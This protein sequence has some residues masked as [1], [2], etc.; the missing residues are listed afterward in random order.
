MT[1]SLPGPEPHVWNRLAEDAGNLFATHTWAECWWRVY[2]DGRE[3]RV[4][5]DDPADPRVILPMYVAGSR[6]RQARF[7]GNGPADQLGP[8]CRPE[9]APRAVEL[10]REALGDKTLRADVVLLQDMPTSRPWWEPLRG[11]RVRVEESPVLQFDQP[12][13]WDDF[14]ASKSKN[15]RNQARAR[16]RRLEEEHGAILRHATTETLA[17]DLDRFFALHAQRWEGVSSLL[18]ERKRRFLTDF[19]TAAHDQG[20][21]RL[22]MLEADGRPVAAS[23]GFR[24]GGDEYYYQMGRDPEWDER[25]VGFVLTV[26]IAREAV[27]T[28]AREMRFLRGDESYKDRFATGPADIETVAVP[29]SALGRVAVPAAALAR[30]KKR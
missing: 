11:R 25:S 5:C 23:L 24:F 17:D 26:R 29:A 22:R 28:G 30:R 10:L 20:W 4:L 16:P 1:S 19:A 9:D 6:L 14:L 21:L 2:G 18:E 15:F 8:V 7:I 27:E 12:T 13:T 3:P